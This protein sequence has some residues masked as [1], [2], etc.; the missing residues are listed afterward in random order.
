MICLGT[1]AG[2][3]LHPDG[4]WQFWAVTISVLTFL[5]PE[6]GWSLTVRARAWLSILAPLVLLGFLWQSKVHF[7]PLTAEV[8]YDWPYA[9]FP[10]HLDDLSDYLFVATALVLSFR[11]VR[12]PMKDIRL[13]GFFLLVA[14][15][16]FFVLE[17]RMIWQIWT[18]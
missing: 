9:R 15:S 6:V 14:S 16:V 4:H 3:E 8:R 18:A 2:Q 17:C 13:V 7:A 1:L 11:A 5:V 10:S 12:L